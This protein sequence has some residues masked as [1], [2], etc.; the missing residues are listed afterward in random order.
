VTGEITESLKAP[1]T[2]NDLQVDGGLFLA[3]VGFDAAPRARVP[4][5][6]PIAHRDPWCE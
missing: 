5:R 3:D 6:D 1:I 2:W 4:A